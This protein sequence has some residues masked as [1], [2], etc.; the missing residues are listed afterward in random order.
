ML[1]SPETTSETSPGTADWRSQAAAVRDLAI[2]RF[3]S[4]ESL[5]SQLPRGRRS[6]DAVFRSADLA[7][8]RREIVRYGGWSQLRPPPDQRGREPGRIHLD[9]GTVGGGQVDAD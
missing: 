1:P 9:H 7:A 5:Q 4:H 6:D 8:Q 2:H 3:D